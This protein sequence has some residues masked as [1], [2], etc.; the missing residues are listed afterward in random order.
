MTE[1]VTLEGRD[2]VVTLSDEDLR[3][4]EAGRESEYSNAYLVAAAISHTFLK[5]L[6]GGA[7]DILSVAVKEGDWQSDEKWIEGPTVKLSTSPKVLLIPHQSS[8]GP[9]P[10]H[11]VYD[12]YNCCFIDDNARCLFV[13]I[14]TIKE[15]FDI[16]LDRW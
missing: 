3:G 1:V 8:T 9:Q 16:L 7:G 14:D 2:F 15:A 11:V 12:L 6:R 10:L 13:A 4:I 5:N